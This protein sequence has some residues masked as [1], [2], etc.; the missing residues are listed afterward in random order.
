MTMARESKDSDFSVTLEG[1][2]DFRFG[3]RTI[4]D[5][6]KIRADYRRI[7]GQDGEDDPELALV[8]GI[9]AAYRQMVV[10]FPAGWADPEKLS[11][12]DLPKLYDLWALWRD[13]EDSFRRGAEEGSQAA[14]A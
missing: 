11:G 1:V 4:G 7:V 13:K 14:G 3:L 2:G 10:S 12:D 5:M 8:A 9:I 6:L